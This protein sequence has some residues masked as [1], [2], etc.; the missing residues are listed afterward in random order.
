VHD[1]TD[2]QSAVILSNCRQAISAEG[3]L[4]LIERV[5]ADRARADRL[6]VAIARADLAMLIGPGGKERTL[7][8]FRDLLDA[9][10]FTLSRVVATELEYSVL[11]AFPR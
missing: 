9:S 11:E 2:A 8:E 4:L 10:G 7:Q 3:R 6:D 5:R 1:W